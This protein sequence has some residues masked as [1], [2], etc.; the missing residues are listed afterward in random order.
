MSEDN[1]TR[2]AVVDALLNWPWGSF[3]GADVKY[4]NEISP[5]ITGLQ[6]L[7]SAR[8]QSGGPDAV[9]PT[10]SPVMTAASS[11]LNQWGQREY[12][13]YD[14]P[15][16]PP[17]PFRRQYRSDAPPRA[18]STGRLTHDPEGRPLG[19]RYI[20]GLTEVDGLN[21]GLWPEEMADV[22]RRLVGR[23]PARVPMRRGEYGRTIYNPPPAQSRN[24]E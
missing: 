5:M 16:V 20:A 22:T 21:V 4:G 17:L 8:I 9:P 12:D 23:D 1:A 18:D 3:P 14:P 24:Q 13:V 10:E 15:P 7:P 11:G 2:R 6:R 19:A